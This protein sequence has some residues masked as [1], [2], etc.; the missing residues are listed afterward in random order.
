MIH[1]GVDGVLEL[2]NLAFNVDGD[3]SRQVSAGHG[4]G[5]LGDIAHLRRQVDGH[6]VDRI[7]KVFPC[8]CDVGH[9]GASAQL[10]FGA[11]FTGHAED[12]GSECVKLVDHRIDGVFQ[13]ENL[14]LHVHRD[15]ARQIASRYGRRH[16]CDVPHLRRQVGRHCIDG[17]GQVLPRSG[18]TRHNC[19]PAEFAFGS[20][21]P[22]NP[23]DLSREG[24]E[25][26]HHRVDGFFELQNLPADVDSNFLGEVAVGHGDHDVGDVANLC[27]QV[28]CHLVHGFGQVLPHARCAFDFCLAAEFSL[29]PNRTDDTGDLG[30]EHRELVD[31][32]VDHL[33]GAQELA[34]QRP[35][36][37][38]ERHRLAKIAFGY[39]ADGARDLRGGPHQVVDQPID[40]DHFVGPSAKRAWNDHSFFQLA[41]FT[42]GFRDPSRFPGPALADGNDVIKRVRHLAFQPG[43]VRR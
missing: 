20:D 32:L 38:F 4:R 7:G 19:L 17:I 27:S 5:H 6:G 30:S 41:L 31:H 16:A 24:T 11:D 2:E 29:G 28:T 14:A 9:F 42:D 36:I 21:L 18:H 37:H 33:G 15:L 40:L 22:G 23:C 43:Q 13:L 8:A 35:T 12:F 34:F 3:F 1:H 10:A 26:I 39:S 25:L